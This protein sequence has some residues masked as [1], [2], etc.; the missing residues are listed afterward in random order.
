MVLSL[1]FC[2]LLARSLGGLRHMSRNGSRDQQHSCSDDG[3][4]ERSRDPFTARCKTFDRDRCRHERHHLQI[5]DPEDE[6][7][8]HQI[9]AA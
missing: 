3:E 9:S 8:Q 4:P 2:L 5:H 6:K 7:D 1:F